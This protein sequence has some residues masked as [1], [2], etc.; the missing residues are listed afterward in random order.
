MNVTDRLVLAGGFN[1]RNYVLNRLYAG[2]G[3]YNDDEKSLLGELNFSAR[4]KDSA[5]FYSTLA[6]F[7]ASVGE[8]GLIAVDKWIYDLSLHQPLLAK[9]WRNLKKVGL[10]IIQAVL[11]LIISRMGGLT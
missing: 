8:R 10:L 2:M 11:V 4:E 1:R 7:L 9:V 3:S 5:N 6:T